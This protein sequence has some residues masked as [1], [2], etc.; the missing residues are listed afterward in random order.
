MT[1]RNVLIVARLLFG[2]LA[3]TAIVVQLSI[4]IQNKASI[5]NF[6]SYFTNLS[7]IFA[8]IVLIIGAIYLIQRREPTATDDV[9]RGASVAA[10][11]L[12]GIVFG[13]L[14]R[15]VDLGSLLPWV[16]VVLHY[17][18]PVV[19]VADWLILPPKTKLTVGRTAYWLVFPALYL[20]YSLIRGARVGFYAYPFL[21]PNPPSPVHPNIAGSYGAVALYCVAILAA[22]LVVGGILMLLGNRLPRNVA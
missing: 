12:V 17:I 20:V 2:L 4:Q 16:N 3:L 1:K 6:F 21:N 14:L 19:V 7:N 13:A 15:D 9:I 10:M 8:A 5:V 11:A 22:F 18:M